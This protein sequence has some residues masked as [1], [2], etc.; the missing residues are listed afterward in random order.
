[1]RTQ[2]GFTLIELIVVIIIV[3]VLAG[4]LLNRVS[5]YQEQAER[6]AMEQVAAAVQSALVLRYGTLLAR[7]AATEQELS[8]LATDN[9]MSWLQKKPRNYAG[10]FYDPSP[11]AVA[12]GR[13]MFDLKSRDLIYVVDRSDHFTPGRDGG[14]WI[15]FHT[16]LQYEPALG[17]SA[18]Q[19]K[20]E[21]VGTL[22]VPTET[23]RWFD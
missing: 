2:R 17:G 8:I 21:L 3:V 7:G 12:P 16:Q 18:Q 11:T 19:G 20:K 15:R 14:K 6:A 23:Y 10:E 1:M 22:L 4:T 5:Y 13:W 9:P